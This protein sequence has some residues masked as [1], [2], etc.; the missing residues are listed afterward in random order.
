MSSKVTNVE[1]QLHKRR[2]PLLKKR[3]TLQRKKERKEER[4]L[5]LE[6][7]LK[8]LKEIG[9]KKKRR[10]SGE[11]LEVLFSRHFIEIGKK[12]RQMEEKRNL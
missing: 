1:S 4:N 2:S 3:K 12:Q 8:V 7:E 5:I 11:T 10:F 6:E 9:V